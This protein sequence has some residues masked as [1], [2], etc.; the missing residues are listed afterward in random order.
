[1]AKVLPWGQ[2]SEGLGRRKS[3]KKEDKMFWIRRKAVVGK[4][5]KWF[6]FALTVGT[7]ADTQEVGKQ[8]AQVC[9]ASPADVHAVLRALPD[10]MARIMESGRSVH[11]DGLGSFYYKLSC[12]GRGVD[13]PEEVSEEQV[14]SI[15]VQFLP[16]R[17]RRTGGSYKRS[18]VGQQIELVEWKKK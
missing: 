17:V 11:I 14:K 3:H 2:E 1:M 5:A 4:R 10:V 9:T 8:I 12:A 13:T 6:P 16:E 15:R 7:P 18:L